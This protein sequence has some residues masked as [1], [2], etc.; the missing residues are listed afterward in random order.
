ML[1][2]YYNDI[3]LMIIFVCEYSVVVLVQRMFEITVMTNVD[4]ML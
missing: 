3:I 4:L 2:L 1:I